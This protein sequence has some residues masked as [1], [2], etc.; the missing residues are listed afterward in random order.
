MSRKQARQEDEAAVAVA[1]LE[2]AGA[3]SEPA[4]GYA[5]LGADLFNAG[6]PP[7]EHAYGR[8]KPSDW[9]KLRTRL[10]EDSGA[11]AEAARLVREA[12]DAAEDA[13]RRTPAY[14][15]H[16]EQE[17]LAAE[18]RANVA[19]AER[20]AARAEQDYHAA[21]AAADEPAALDAK[22]RA[23]Q[24]RDAAEFRGNQVAARQVRLDELL[25]ALRTERDR[26]LLAARAELIARVKE[27]RADPATER[28]G[29]AV[30]ELLGEAALDVL[31]AQAW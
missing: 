26:L 19:E 9:H 17:R 8:E 4:E 30:W 22:G 23:R 7:R 21:C 12:R 1:E 11:C 18:A 29:K 16:A 2:A 20:A 3:A 6:G 28:L 15:D 24:A 13:L 25:P 5:A 14:R 31:V 27:Q 10:L